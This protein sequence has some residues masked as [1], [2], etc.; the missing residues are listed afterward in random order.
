MDN[1]TFGSYTA[2]RP[3]G[4]LRLAGLVMSRCVANLGAK[5]SSSF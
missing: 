1:E 3:A 2:E 5:L 4:L